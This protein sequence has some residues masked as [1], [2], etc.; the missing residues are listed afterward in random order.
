MWDART[1]AIA[2]LTDMV[3]WLKPNDQP[4]LYY[5]PQLL[6]T[7][8]FSAV[9]PENA[10]AF[11]ELALKEQSLPIIEDAKN[12]LNRL[13]EPDDG[14]LKRIAPDI[15]YGNRSFFW[16]ELGGRTK[17]SDVVMHIFHKTVFTISMGKPT[18]PP[19]ENHPE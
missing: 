18:P 1:Q 5:L 12:I 6:T 8:E 17:P 13:V 11:A 7:P 15:F 10:V 3:Y 4:F 9:R 2:K 16:N 14:S 19:Q